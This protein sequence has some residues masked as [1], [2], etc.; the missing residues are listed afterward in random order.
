ML[1]ILNNKLNK[2]RKYPGNNCNGFGICELRAPSSRGKGMLASA[3]K[4]LGIVTQLEMK[5][6]EAAMEGKP[7]GTEPL[8]MITSWILWVDELKTIKSEAK[9]LNNSILLSPKFQMK[10]TKPSYSNTSEVSS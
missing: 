2:L 3:F 9:M 8:A 4:K 7:V 5:E 1:N 6:I 10:T